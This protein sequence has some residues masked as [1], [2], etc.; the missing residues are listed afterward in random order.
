[1][2][3]SGD[4]APTLAS[5]AVGMLCSTVPV[6]LRRSSSETCLTRHMGY[7]RLGHAMVDVCQRQ[8][9]QS[10][11]CLVPSQARIPDPAH[12]AAPAATPLADIV[13]MAVSMH[14]R[15]TKHGSSGARRCQCALL[16][17]L[18]INLRPPRDRS[19]NGSTHPKVRTQEGGSLQSV[20]NSL[21]TLLFLSMTGTIIHASLGRSSS[22]AKSRVPCCACLVHSVHSSARTSS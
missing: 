14:A 12:I 4:T 19:S 16:L 1:M 6:V 11:S 17:D 15:N 21:R 5:A 22:L 20:P 7:R 18:L 2:Q 3:C 9:R 10:L 8:S 13:R